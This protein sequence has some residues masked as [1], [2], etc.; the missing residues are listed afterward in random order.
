MIS[1]IR[2][3]L[4]KPANGTLSRRKRYLWF[5]DHVHS[6]CYHLLMRW[7]FFPL[8]GEEEVKR[9]LLAEIDF[10]PQDRI[11]DMCCGP[12]NTTFVIAEMLGGQCVIRGIDLSRGQIENARK[13]N[14]FPNLQF[15]VMDAERTA[16]H[17]EEFDKVIISF[18]L[19]E[20]FSDAR[21]AVLREAKRILT[22][23][24][25]LTILE[26]DNP[27]RLSDRLFM[28]FWLFYWLP[29]NFE[30]P[31]RRDMLRRGL[32]EEVKEVGFRNVRKASLY[33][34]VFQ[35]VQGQSG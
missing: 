16:F 13:K 19:H 26:L 32:M 28:G 22:D 1:T 30:T 34:G 14:R 15:F 10:Q 17:D 23:G 35:V 33:K 25:T 11:L 27:S 24:G 20:M 2:D 6:R 9:T 31:T 7:C 3:K 5:Y 8:G 12:G 4:V 18:A 29:F 21:L